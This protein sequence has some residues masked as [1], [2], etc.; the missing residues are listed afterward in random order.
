VQ[1]GDQLV[2]LNGVNVVGLGT[3]EITTILR[4][5]A[6]DGLERAI[7]VRR[8]QEGQSVR[9]C[10]VSGVVGVG[11][12][13]GSSGVGSTVASVKEDAAG[14]EESQREEEFQAGE[15]GEA[16][17]MREVGVV[18]SFEATILAQLRRSYEVETMASM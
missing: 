10:G 15:A 5:V 18:P 8:Y 6:G 4:E 17:V 2:G 14:E 3:T 1:P 9:K 12:G 7:K 11:S 13:V 16:P